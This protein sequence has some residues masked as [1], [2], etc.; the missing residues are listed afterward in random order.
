[1]KCIH[2]VPIGEDCVL[3]PSG[4]LRRLKGTVLQYTG[5]TLIPTE[6]DKVL[7]A[8]KGRLKRVTII[9]EDDNGSFYFAASHSDGP[10]NLWALEMAKHKLLN[11]V[12]ESEK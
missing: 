1:M 8:A 9:G 10:E 7:E 6:P 2:D 5:T 3:C 11:I 4:N 12:H